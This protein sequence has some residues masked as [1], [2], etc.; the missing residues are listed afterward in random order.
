MD[1]SN[2]L[3]IWEELCQKLLASMNQKAFD[4][5]IKPLIPIEMTD[6]SFTVLVQNSFLKNIVESRYKSLIEA[7]LSEI[8]GKNLSLVFEM[9]DSPTQSEPSVSIPSEKPKEQELFAEVPET[10][11]YSET[12]LN[13]H[14]VF[15]NFV[16]GNSNR[17][18]HAAAQ[19]VAND[20]GHAYNPFFIWGGVGLGKTHLMHAIGN[21]IVN[22]NPSL[23]VVYTSCETFTN[24]IINA[25]A[26]KSTEAF[27]KKYRSIDCLIIDDIQFLKNKVAT[28]E[29]FFHTFNELRDAEKQIIISSDRR[30]HEIETL[31]DRLRSRFE[32]GLIADI[33]TPDLETRIAILRSK[34]Q[35]DNIELPND[36]VNLLSTSITT[37]V[38]EIE[39]AYTKIKA[40]SSL[41]NM[42]ITLDIAQKVI[43][44]IGVETP[45][46]QIT[47][48][49]IVKAVTELHKLKLEDFYSKN[50]SKNIAFP[51]Q[52]AMYLC[53]ELTGMSFPQIAEK[54]GGRDH[55]T[56]MHAYKKIATSIT[57]DKNLQNEIKLLI[58]QL[59][60]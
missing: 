29:E 8:S 33:S 51:R 48:D 44:E 1:S 55:T 60:D 58:D 13:P 18:A 25:I 10:Q 49:A 28:Q 52:I 54:F 11:D 40:I 31:E 38:R 23:K 30:P 32:Q 27:R 24:E 19:A 26:T 37:N 4:I 17:L 14:Y 36:V 53:R 41:L 35:A 42:P 9:E 3:K 59:Q 7:A 50:R 12:K 43:S 20:P 2:I 21:S 39:G 5:Y 34:A 57:I 45:Q 15:E 46:K 22:N 16:I 47:A 56:V 6:A